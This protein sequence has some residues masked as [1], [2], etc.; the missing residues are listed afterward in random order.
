MDFDSITEV[1]GNGQSSQPRLLPRTLGVARRDEHAT[2][3]AD[4]RFASPGEVTNESELVPQVERIR[5][6]IF[7][8][9]RRSDSSAGIAGHS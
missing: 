2:D 9:N 5:F 1:V 8:L 7:Q 3:S 4:R 6:Q